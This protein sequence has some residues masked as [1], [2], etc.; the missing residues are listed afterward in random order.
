[1]KRGSVS[2][3]QE[4]ETRRRALAAAL[5]LLY[6]AGYRNLTIEAVARSAGVSK[7]TIYRHWAD[8]AHL[9]LEA[10]SERAS[11]DTVVPDTGDLERDLEQ[12]LARVA[13]NLG[14]GPNRGLGPAAPVVAE[15]IV[16]ANRD[17][18]FAEVYRAT[19]LKER[20]RGFL[21]IFARARQRGQLADDIDLAVL[22]DSVFGALHH[23]LL[24]TAQPIDGAFVRALVRIVVHGAHAD[25]R[26]DSASS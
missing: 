13:Q 23:R 7:S 21:T 4:S 9:V 25:P 11:R 3:E 15:L 12:H 5:E 2:H 14:A 19:V 1:M 26:S 18:V 17:P 8:K 10:F 16:E 22:V 24:L 20:R 6:H